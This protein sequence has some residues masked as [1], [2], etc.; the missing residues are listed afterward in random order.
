MGGD[1][2]TQLGLTLFVGVRILFGFLGE[3]GSRCFGVFGLDYP[4]KVLGN[5][6][7]FSYLI[8]CFKIL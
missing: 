4:G 2:T 5:F 7:L 8:Y 1:P 6:F 3:G